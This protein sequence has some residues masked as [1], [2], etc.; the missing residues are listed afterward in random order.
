MLGTDDIELFVPI[1]RA[2]RPSI[3]QYQREILILIIPFVHAEY[4]QTVYPM[5]C[6]IYLLLQQKWQSR[7]QQIA[8]PFP[9]DAVSIDTFEDIDISSLLLFCMTQYLQRTATVI[10]FASYIVELFILQWT[11][12]FRMCRSWQIGILIF[13]QKQFFVR[14]CYEIHIIKNTELGRMEHRIQLVCS[15]ICR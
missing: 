15:P 3:F 13:H 11:E 7:R 9:Q 14:F 6:Q 2:F 12:I 1:I 10:I 8:Y 4:F 5:F